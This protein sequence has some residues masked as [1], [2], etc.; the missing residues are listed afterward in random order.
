MKCAKCN[1]ESPNDAR[2]CIECG[3]SVFAAATGV[4]TRIGN[5]NET[6]DY[7]VLVEGTVAGPYIPTREAELDLH[8]LYFIYRKDLP[9]LLKQTNTFVYPIGIGDYD[10]YYM[11]RKVV[12]ID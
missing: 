12:F 11:G 7:K 2:F 9:A 5:I 4:T 6:N 10:I 1:G 3:A 8:Q